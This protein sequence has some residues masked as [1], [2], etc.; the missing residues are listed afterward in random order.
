MKTNK[1]EKGILVGYY[2]TPDGN[3]IR[4]KKQD[5]ELCEYLIDDLYKLLY[6]KKAVECFIMAYGIN[7]TNYIKI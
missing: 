2:K 1:E 6:D 4:L 7:S 3:T 5:I